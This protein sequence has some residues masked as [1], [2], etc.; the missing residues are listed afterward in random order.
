VE[1]SFLDWFM[2]SHG[3]Y[4]GER[5]G[6]LSQGHWDILDNRLEGTNLGM[7]DILLYLRTLITRTD[8]QSFKVGIGCG[9]DD[10][11][12]KQTRLSIKC[13]HAHYTLS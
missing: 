5:W 4:T 8:Y 1:G 10:G 9:L 3:E 12:D 7:R 11:G 2:R 13:L 6:T